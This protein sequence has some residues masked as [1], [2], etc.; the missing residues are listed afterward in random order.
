VVRPHPSLGHATD[1]WFLDGTDLY[2]VRA[3]APDAEWLGG[4]IREF[5]LDQLTL[6]NGSPPGDF[7]FQEIVSS[8]ARSAAKGSSWTA[9]FVCTTSP[10]YAQP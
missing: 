7:L 8:I 4:Y 9:F 6:A 2:H 5:L 3:Y 10:L 1:A